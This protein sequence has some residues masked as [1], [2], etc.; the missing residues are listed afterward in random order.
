MAP[1]FRLLWQYWGP[2]WARYGKLLEAT[3]AFG[4]FHGWRQRRLAGKKQR[5][6]PLWSAWP[7]TLNFRKFYGLKF[8][9]A[10]KE[11]A[12]VGIVAHGKKGYGLGPGTQERW[13]KAKAQGL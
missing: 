8:Y 12:R 11:H 3:W 7:E 13:K 6:T 4:L 10:L 5:P 1:E 9:Y 2:F